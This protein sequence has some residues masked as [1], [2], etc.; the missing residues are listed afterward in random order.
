[1]KLRPPVS[2]Q[3]DPAGAPG[4]DDGGFFPLL[5]GADWFW[6]R[7]ETHRSHTRRALHRLSASLPLGTLDIQR[8]LKALAGAKAHR[9]SALSPYYLLFGICG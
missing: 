3:V 4:H 6:V 7:G 8:K 1:M 5:H 2:W 9:N